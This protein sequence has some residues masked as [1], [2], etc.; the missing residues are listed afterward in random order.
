MIADSIDA[1]RKGDS[2]MLTEDLRYYWGEDQ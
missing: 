2:Q 1:V